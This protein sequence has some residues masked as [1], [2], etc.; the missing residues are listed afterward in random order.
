MILLG[1]ILIK[2][3][4]I[5]FRNVYT[6]FYKNLLALVTSA[7]SQVLIQIIS[8]PLFL[9]YLNLESYAIW[10]LSYNVAQI[11]GLL[12]F[13]SIA[14]SQNKLSELNSQNKWAEID[15]YLK[16]VINILVLSSA[17][18]LI[19]IFLL[20]ISGNKNLNSF[21]IIVFVVLNFLQSSWGLLEALTRFDS[22][23]AMGLYTSNALR[24]S[25]FLG[26]VI[27][28][29]IFSNSLLKIALIS[30]FFKFS[31]FLFMLNKLSHRYNF[32][33]IGVINWNQIISICKKSMPFFL[34]KFTDVISLS[35]LLIVLHGKMSTNHF[36]LF[37]A[38]RTFFRFGLQVTGLIAHTYAYEMSSSWVNRDFKAM[39]GLI[40]R[41][42]RINLIMSSIGMLVYLVAGKYIFSY[43]VNEK[44]EINNQMI[45]WGAC[46]S[47]ILSV[48]QNQKT[49]FYA[50]NHSF[51]VSVIQISCSAMLVLT[52]VMSVNHFSV[53]N[54]FILLSIFE[55]ICFFIVAVIS[56]N[57]INQYFQR[58]KT[59]DRINDSK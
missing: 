45:V 25:E 47:F 2:R 1:S 44:F 4:K 21:L 18:F 49:K 11:S 15:S 55:L 3:R 24:L 34:A 28:V 6:N 12:D 53:V 32:L 39:S 37:V 58:L 46:Y 56:R 54:L 30:L 36:V 17:L 13:G 50:I 16:Q 57:S 29:I 41:S 20:Q 52:I 10:L 7:A 35:G 27:G 43:W 14:Y 19:T 8:L 26:T 22:R 23:I 33:R 48:N 42:N 5:S 51:L 40:K 59:S 31:A 38:T 9:T